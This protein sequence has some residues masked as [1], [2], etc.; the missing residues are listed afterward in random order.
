MPRLLLATLLLLAPPLLAQEAQLLPGD[1]FEGAVGSDTDRDELG[2]QALGGSLLTVTVKG[3]DG[4]LPQLELLSLPGRAPLD[5]SGFLAGAGGPKLTLKNLP[6]PQDGD[7]LLAVTAQPGT[8]GPYK[9][10]TKAKVP[11]ALKSFSS[12]GA[13]EPGSLELAFSALPGTQLT[14][15]VK[16]S[17]GAVATPGVPLVHSEKTASMSAGAG[18]A[19][20]ATQAPAMPSATRAAHT[21]TCLIRCK[22]TMFSFSYRARV[23]V[24]AAFFFRLLIGGRL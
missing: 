24:R 19:S 8:S 16:A 13:A 7:Y 1:S 12:D 6:L 10:T 23:R 3:K 11:S 22:F 17:K 18:S 4:L 5:L 14:A 9:L 21:T 2:L 15:T 20:R